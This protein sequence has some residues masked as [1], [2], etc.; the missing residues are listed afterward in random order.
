MR[1]D[2]EKKFCWPKHHICTVEKSY[3]YEN[4]RLK[5]MALHEYLFNKGFKDA[6][7]AK[8]DVLPTVRC[9]IEMCKR[10]DIDLEQYK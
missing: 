3:H 8:N 1:H 9:F 10:G 7:R 5:L 6:H 2:L 4:K